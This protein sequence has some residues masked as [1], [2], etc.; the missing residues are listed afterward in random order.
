MSVGC[1]SGVCDEYGQGYSRLLDPW[2][3]LKI[4]CVVKERK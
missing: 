4:A 2:W 1:L 3:P